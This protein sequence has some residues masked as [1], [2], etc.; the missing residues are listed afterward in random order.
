MSIWKQLLVLAVMAG[1]AYGGYEAYQRYMMTEAAPER[2][3]PPRGGRAATVELSSVE[4]RKLARLVEA[5]G[6]TR[7]RQSIEI[8]PE[9]SGRVEKIAFD[10]GQ[11]VEAGAVLVQLD[12]AIAR[13][14]L[15]EADAQL[16][17]RRRGLDRLN[18][19][20]GSSSV[21]E[22]AIEQAVARFAEAQAQVDRARQRLA[23]RTIRAPFSGTV[24]LPEADIG[25]RVTAGTFITRLDDLSEVEVEFSLPETLF[26]QIIP[27]QKVIA[28]SA[29][30]P[31]RSF[32]GAVDAVDSR[33]D[34]VSRSFRT[35]AIIPNPDGTLPAG[36]FM[37]LELTLEEF[38]RL[39]VPEEAI[40][41]QAAETYVFT[42]EDGTA[43]RI[44]V[45]TGQR[46]DGL[47]AVLSG[48]EAG[49]HVV[50]RGLHRVRDGGPVNVLSLDGE[51]PPNEEAES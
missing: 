15:A 30:F 10:A 50:I 20:R 29:A 23:E 25:A 37:S 45:R 17:E 21:S 35:R 49:M 33:I 9:A 40:V 13:A 34:P 46:R 41:F 32:A 3:G 48:L 36:M 51:T 18:Q 31:D 38:D 5:V 14:D 39:V 1:L 42:V 16:V 27:G 24:G 4:T 19:L 26:A 2:G 43:R 6:T 7:A 47:V 44:P 28:T 12:D 22:A 8:V 11:A